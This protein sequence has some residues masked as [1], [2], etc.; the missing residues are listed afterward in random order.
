[1]PSAGRFSYPLF[2]RLRAGVPQGSEL[3]AMSRLMRTNT[4]V[5]GEHEITPARTQ[6]VSGSFFRVLGVRAVRGRIL[7]EEDNRQLDGNPVTVIAEGFWKRR[8]G[9]TEDVIGR[10]IQL[11]GCNFTIVGV[12]QT[13]FTGAWVE[14][15]SDLW[16]PLTMQ[17]AVRYEQNYSNSDGD[18]RKPW[19]PQE[20]IRWLDIVL[21]AAANRAQALSAL[22]VT[23]Q[24]DREREAGL[25]TNPAEKRLALEHKLVLDPFAHGFSN[26]RK[27][28]EAPLLLLMAMV[29]AMLL[30]ACANLANLMLA[31]SAARQREIAVRMSI[32]AGRA[33]L[34]RQ[35]LTESLVIALLGGAAGVL[36]ARW[37]V[38]VLVRFALGRLDIPPA[39]ALDWPV[40]AFAAG[41]SFLTGILFG[42][43]PA[44]RVTRVELGRT[45]QTGGRNLTGGS[46][47]SGMR[48]LVIA[49][50]AL[51][52]TLLLAAGLFSRSLRNVT[53]IDPGF[54]EAHLVSAVIDPHSA[55]YPVNE[56]PGL[57][58]RLVERIRTLPGVASAAAAVCGLEAGCNSFSDGIQVE[59]YQARVGEQVL[60]QENVVGPGYFANAGIPLHAGRDIDVHDD[61]HGRRVA[62]INEALARRYFPNRN[63][64]GMR[65]GYKKPDTEIIGVVGDVRV[66]RLQEPAVPMVWY[67]LSQK[68]DYAETIDVRTAGDPA[69][70]ASALRE[71][72]REVDPNLPLER[73]IT[74]RDQIGSN[75]RQERLIAYLTS[76]FGLLALILASVGLYGVMSYGVARRTSEIGV[77]M[78]IGAGQRDVLWMMLRESL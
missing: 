27:Q 26:L 8:F 78:A 71:A 17:H 51:S 52:L 6:L 66:T 75:L 3:F 35:L 30:I 18:S 29:G 19:L 13:G 5:A 2:Q 39:F 38:D 60:F 54:D 62:V 58:Q 70:I 68:P 57:Y 65:F 59:G 50:V 34:V 12:I 56:L 55:G 64:L 53:Q 1:R 16:I 7:S 47:S 22:N 63:P 37:T 45:L 43:L 28:F 49:Q 10:S 33:R 14:T 72:I 46:Q 32:G 77:R 15:P 20:Q 76:A 42:L 69:S 40:L 61:L 25:L 74:L 9:G 67:A 48:P 21:R 41:L 31:R 24:Q 23:F 4:F 73:V 36:V 44:V 11:N